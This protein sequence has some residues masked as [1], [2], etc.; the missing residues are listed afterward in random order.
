MSKGEL[1]TK[2][3]VW[4]A[5]AGYATG[6]S[7]YLL[8]RGRRR[9]D[10]V[11]RMA[12]TAGCAG[13][14]LHVACA[15]HYYHNW[16]QASAYRETARQTAEVTGMNWGGGLF[17]N[18]ALIVGWIADAVWWRRGL[19]AYRNRPRWL[20]SA[21]QGFLI[22]IIFNATVVFKTG[23]LRWIGLGLCL[24]LVFLWLF[25]SKTLGRSEAKPNF[26]E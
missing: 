22:F 15:L 21:W 8:S 11:A 23:P 16:S 7:V 6:A 20:A 9:W 2:I 18:Y 12:W 19:D 17:I 5:L 4:L 10:E 1:L 13:L 24:W 14:L 3:T 25:V 26:K